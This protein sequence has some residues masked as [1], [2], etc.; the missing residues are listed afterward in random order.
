M[1][2]KTVQSLLLPIEVILC[3]IG[4]VLKSTK[5]TQQAGANDP[6][7]HTNYREIGIFLNGEK[8]S[9]WGGITLIFRYHR[10]CNK[11]G[12]KYTLIG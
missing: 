1:N 5:E 10:S 8:V 2:M 9:Q 11:P 7:G 6:P 4:P 3:S 12:T